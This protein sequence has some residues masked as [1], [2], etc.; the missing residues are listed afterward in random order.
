MEL[1]SIYTLILVIDLN[2][3]N[4]NNLS[5]WTPS[6][7]YTV[8]LFCFHK[9]R[10]FTSLQVALTG[11]W[12]LYIYKLWAFKQNVIWPATSCEWVGV[13]RWFLTSSHCFS[14]YF[15]SRYVQIRTSNWTCLNDKLGRVARMWQMNIITE[16]DPWSSCILMFLSVVGYK[17]VSHHFI[18]VGGGSGWIRKTDE[19]REKQKRRNNSSWV[20][21]FQVSKFQTS[22]AS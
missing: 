19:V 3:V 15:F 21:F 18:C 7:F 6:T 22:F 1:R 5:Y 20:I 2:G 11:T 8:S 9:A 13:V 12:D 10:G 16:F 14:S 4:S 17:Q